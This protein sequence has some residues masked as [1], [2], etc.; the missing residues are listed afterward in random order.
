MDNAAVRWLLTTKN[1]NSM[2]SKYQLHVSPFKF[3]L[4]HRAGKLNGNADA[5][6]RPVLLASQEHHDLHEISIK[7]LDPYEDECLLNYLNYRRHNSTK[8]LK[9]SITKK[10]N[11]KICQRTFRT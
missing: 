2:L 8:S 10:F 5:L 4:L 7:T 9:V 1:P 6:S 3:K 11:G